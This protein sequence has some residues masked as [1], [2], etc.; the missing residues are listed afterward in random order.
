MEAIAFYDPGADITCQHT[1]GAQGGIG[2]GWPTSRNAGG[3]A[4]ISDAGDGLLIVTTPAAKAA[5]FGV[6]SVDVAAGGR[7]D[8]MRAPKVVPIQ[9]AAACNIGDDLAITATGKATPAVTGDVI[10]GKCLMAGTT[11][12][13]AA[14]DLYHQPVLKP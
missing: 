8:V 12:T 6:T 4:G 13:M 14:V 2:V 9:C 5:I 7:V 3:P 10:I 1:A 11:T